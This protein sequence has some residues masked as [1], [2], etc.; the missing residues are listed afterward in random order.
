MRNQAFAEKRCINMKRKTLSIFLIAVLLFSCIQ[1]SFAADT[2][3][4][5][6]LRLSKT[7][8][9]V[10]VANKNDKI[11]SLLADMKL[12]NGYRVST[13]LASYAYVSLD[14]S[15]SVK[16]DAQ[17]KA[18]IKE[19]GKKLE[20][21]LSAGKLFF[22]VA[23]P[24]DTDET[25]N[26]RTSTMVTGVR[27]TAGWFES[28]SA[29]Q[30][31][32]YILEGEVTV[33]SVNRETGVTWTVTAR[34][35]EAV[36][37]TITIGEDGSENVELS[38]IAF[39]EDTVP[40][41]V[42]VAVREDP[43][44]QRRISENSPLSVP[45]IIGDADVRLAS[46][47]RKA[48]ENWKG[49]RLIVAGQT[50][51]VVDPFFKQ[52]QTVA[53]GGGLT[54]SVTL[55]GAIPYADVVTALS[56]FRDVTIA[57]GSSTS[58]GPSD[59]I[60]ISSGQNMINDGAIYGSLGSNLT[61]SGTFTN[62]GM[63]S[64]LT[65][66]SNYSTSSFYNNGIGEIYV[67]SIVNGSATHPGRMILSGTTVQVNIDIMNEAGSTMQID[68]LN[69]QLD[70]IT[71]HGTLEM[72][73]VDVSGQIENSGTITMQHTNLN[74]STDAPALVM[75]GGTMTVAGD[76]TFM[77]SSPGGL[78][79]QMSGGTIDFGGAGIFA[80]ADDAIAL[81]LNGGAFNHL[82]GGIT[83]DGD[84]AVGVKMTE[85]TLTISDN[86]GL[87]ALGFPS[88]IALDYYGGTLNF[89]SDSGFNTNDGA[90]A[91]VMNS[92]SCTLNANWFS[93]CSG[94]AIINNGGALTLSGGTAEISTL[95]FIRNLAGTIN[96]GNCLLS[97]TGSD[98]QP[99]IENAGTL[100]FS[101]GSTGKI[102]RTNEETIVSNTGSGSFL[103]SNGDP[104]SNQPQ[105]DGTYFCLINETP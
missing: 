17:S 51:E 64:G 18:S 42:R 91:F 96:L 57:N 103:N 56:G 105:N 89:S 83:G 82:Y 41:F 27:G 60:N 72:E 87:G 36:I 75:T 30:S 88:A 37:S 55:T 1:F 94:T 58:L 52:D 39:H 67:E 20:L 38:V 6:T 53:G 34:A 85:G 32:L 12:F 76:S 43:E 63:I 61:I 26:I 47:Q 13:D 44:L 100:R 104:H 48:Q 28:W 15:K 22:N 33:V 49:I 9:T 69:V 74:A 65:S 77:T 14:S 35:G 68:A 79:I 95:P 54:G 46:D 66:I 19:S 11:L 78:V 80:V 70:N 29:T 102:Q 4:G 97:Y 45:L 71:N 90:S 24:L 81:E 3:S 62:N 40:G 101:A 92:G 59:T 93:Q 23:K 73:G 99:M 10:K 31:V 86:T 25:L 50:N 98:T 84:R 5:T 7:E 2:A 8:G 16:L 21:Q